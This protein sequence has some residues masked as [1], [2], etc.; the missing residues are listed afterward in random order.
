MLRRLDGAPIEG[1][2]HLYAIPAR[3]RRLAA[4]PDFALHCRRLMAERGLTVRELVTRSGLDHRTVK[5]VLRGSRPQ[6][7]TL[8]SLARGLGVPTSELFR[9]PPPHA[10]QAFDRA[11]N[12][13][14]ARTLEEHPELFL[15]WTEAEFAELESRV[16]TGG[17]L[18]EQG[19][20][21]AVQDMNRNRRVQQ[22]VAV[23][24]ETSH[25]TLLAALV[26]AM[27]V[28]VVPSAQP[29]TPAEHAPSPAGGSAALHAETRFLARG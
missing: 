7:R 15:D 13:A 2:I 1:T 16:A 24:L 3:P 23:L 10:A 5:A 27:Y 14:V 20:L 9:E 11:T 8:H 28:Q 18:R 21:A 19:V 17:A 29:H 12:A 25:A 4:M 26:E 22:Q 6:P